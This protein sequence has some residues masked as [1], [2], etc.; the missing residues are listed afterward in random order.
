MKPQCILRSLLLAVGV[1]VVFASASFAQAT[2]SCDLTTSTNIIR[3]PAD[4]ETAQPIYLDGMTLDGQGHTITAIEDGTTVPIN[5][6]NGGIIRNTIGGRSFNVKNLTLKYVRNG[7][8]C[9][10]KNSV[11][12]DSFGQPMLVDDRLVGILFDGASGS[13]KNTVV[14]NINRGG[15]CGEGN[16]IEVRNHGTLTKVTLSGNTVTGYGKTGIVANGIVDVTITDNLVDAQLGGFPNTVTVINGIQ[17]GDG[18]TGT[19]RGNTVTGNRTTAPVGAS[20]AGILVSGGDGLS[21]CV[22][23][24]IQA[25][26]LENNDVGV[27]LSQKTG[28]VPA[29]TKTG[30]R[31]AGNTITNDFATNSYQAG[32]SVSGNGDKLSN[33][34]ISG[35]GYAVLIDLTGGGNAAPFLE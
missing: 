31:V 25:N 19:V 29:D 27:F 9:G 28:G 34:K 8:T 6:F 20:S 23:L 4:C 18:A 35:A 14:N 5:H 33:N 26:T 32:I 13:V 11:Y 15:T 22:G 7:S 3:L 30:T 12:Y 21:Y 10:S 1:A 2:N 16:G 24:T 17:L